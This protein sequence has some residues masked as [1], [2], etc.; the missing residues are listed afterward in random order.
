MYKFLKN[1]NGLRKIEGKFKIIWYTRY[2]KHKINIQ[3]SSLLLK[4][5]KKKIW[6][7][8]LNFSII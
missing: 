4:V 5:I 7:I 1:N 2:D 6:R 3:L 8:S